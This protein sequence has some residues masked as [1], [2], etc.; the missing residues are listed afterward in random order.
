MKCIK[1]GL[2]LGLGLGLLKSVQAT[3]GTNHKKTWACAENIIEKKA[4][5]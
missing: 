5:P 1:F 2:G 3:D 4:L